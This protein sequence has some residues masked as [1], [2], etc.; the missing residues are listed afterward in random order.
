[1]PDFP[2]LVNESPGGIAITAAS[3]E[4]SLGGAFFQYVLGS[5]VITTV[6]PGANH[7][8]FFPFVISEW[9]SIE[10]AIWENGATVAGNVSIGIYDS[11]Q[12]CCR[13]SAGGFA[14]SHVAMTGASTTQVRAFSNAVVLPPGQYYGGFSSDSAT[15]TLGTFAAAANV[16]QL[17][18]MGVFNQLTAYP[19]PTPKATFIVAADLVVPS[20]AFVARSVA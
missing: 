11:Q 15:A 13:D 6:W 2:V 1:M 12:N 9:M 5:P 18:G 17:R 8:I 4:C 19:L 3:M 20:V 14:E 16:G 10:R 7:A